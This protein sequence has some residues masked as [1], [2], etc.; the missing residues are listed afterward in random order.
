MIREGRF[1]RQLKD[2]S[3]EECSY[4]IDISDGGLFSMVKKAAKN[5]TGKSVDGAHPVTKHT[6]R[7]M[8]KRDTTLALAESGL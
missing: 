6:L 2:G 3:I 8:E 7:E 1:N 5:K 4:R